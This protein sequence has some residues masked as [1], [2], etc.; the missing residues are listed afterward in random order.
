MM[1]RSTKTN[2]E[3]S[4]WDALSD[5]ERAALVLLA[6]TELG[7]PCLEARNSDRDDFRDVNVL[8]VRHALA[9]AFRAGA[10]RFALTPTV[11]LRR[12]ARPR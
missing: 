4:P 7:F 3:L 5:D 8:S 1:R 12:R 10:G 6:Q 2:P 11:G 9:A